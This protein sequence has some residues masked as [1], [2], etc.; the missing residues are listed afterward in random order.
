MSEQ[1]PDAPVTHTDI[2]VTDQQ[3]EANEQR[4]ESNDPD[5]FVDDGT[6]GGL[7]GSDQQGGGAG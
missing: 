5:A 3:I 7:G 4:P 6:L 2:G 1:P